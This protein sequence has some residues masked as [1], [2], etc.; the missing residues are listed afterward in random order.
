MLPLYQLVVF[1]HQHSGCV[2]VHSSIF[3]TYFCDVMLLYL[4]HFLSGCNTV[5]SQTPGK[6]V[7]KMLHQ[8]AILLL[9]TI[10]G[11]TG[12]VNIIDD[13]NT[14][15]KTLSP[16]LYSKSLAI[17]TPKL[18]IPLASVS[19]CYLILLSLSL[20]LLGLVAHDSM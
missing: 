11:I 19:R 18:N 10:L 13:D 17:I 4:R 14:P 6:Q 3:S 2:G 15:G 12:S 8:F 1:I 7:M 5:T 20:Q 9:A 16:I